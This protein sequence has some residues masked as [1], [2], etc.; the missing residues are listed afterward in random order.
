MMN[1]IFLF[2]I[3]VFGFGGLIFLI[4]DPENSTGKELRRGYRRCERTT[5]ANNLRIL[6]SAL[7]QTTLI[8]PFT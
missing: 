2:P 7:I 6:N 5:G 4:I 8:F 3:M 1:Y